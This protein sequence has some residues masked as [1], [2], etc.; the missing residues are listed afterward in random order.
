MP[1]TP[2]HTEDTKEIQFSSSFDSTHEGSRALSKEEEALKKE[3]REGLNQLNPDLQYL[4][5]IRSTP[6]EGATHYLSDKKGHTYNPRIGGQERAWEDFPR[7][8][9][10]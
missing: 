6:P 9:K 1:K 4:S 2:Q 7:S 8:T 10:S 5:S 3:L